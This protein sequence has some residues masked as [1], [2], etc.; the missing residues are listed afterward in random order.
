VTKHGLLLSYS[1]P[2]IPYPDDP[3]FD[4]DPVRYANLY[5]LW[6]CCGCEDAVLQKQWASDDSNEELKSAPIGEYY[7]TRLTDVTSM[8]PKQFMRLGPELKQLYGEIIACY[9]AGS[10]LLCSM[11]LRAMIEG[12]CA[13]KGLKHKELWKN[14]DGLLEFMPNQNLIDY[15]HSFKFVGNESAH[16]LQALDLDEARI[17]I[18]VL[19]DLLNFL[20]DLDYKASKMKHA[21]RHKEFKSHKGG[22][23]H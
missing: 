10:L 23:V 11:G 18:D 4:C 16:G 7:P 1:T 17:Q 19:E 6:S 3:E 8:R 5:S 20:Y 2:R 13:D 12:V 14:I 22:S 21:E 9:N 15:L